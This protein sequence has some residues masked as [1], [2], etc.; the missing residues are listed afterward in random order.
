MIDRCCISLTEKCNLCCRYCHFSTSGRRSNDMSPEEAE[1]ILT[2]ILKYVRK[3]NRIFK[4]G[5]VGGGEPTLRFNLMKHVVETLEESKNIHIYTI[6]N[7][8]NISGD[9]LD[10]FY[11]HRE[12]VEFCIS[13]DGDKAL[14]D[15]NRIDF[16]GKGTYDRILDTVSG[17]CER[18]G[19]KPSINCTV[20]PEHISES[21]RLIHF[22][23][24]QGYEKV[25]FSKLFDSDQTV[26]YKEFS[27]LLEK[28][29]DFL[30]IRQLR[31]TKTYDCIQYGSL[32][33]VGR[34]NIYYTAG[35]VY[36]CARFS[37][38]SEYCIGTA[39]DSIEDIEFRLSSLSP[40]E[41]GQ[42]Y[43][44]QIFSMRK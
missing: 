7:G 26:D 19:H 43:Y 32:C 24:D 31:K 40:C 41:N 18:F 23:S 1:A 21:D 38:I 9:M 6:S 17:Y 20:T 39:Y 16:S 30:E 4:V 34:T 15:Q 12:S 10:F 28:A 5:L 22:F 44:E 27:A 29:S 14:N 37:G 3:Q 36:P 8:V 35:K 33:G 42:C 11:E 25:T 2:S 13:L